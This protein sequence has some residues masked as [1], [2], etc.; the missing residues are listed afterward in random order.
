GGLQPGVRARAMRLLFTGSADSEVGEF[1]VAVIC[2]IY[3]VSNRSGVE[4]R[5]LVEWRFGSEH[6]DFANIFKRY[7]R[8][9]VFRT[10]GNVRAE[11]TGLRH[12]F[13]NLMR[14]CIDHR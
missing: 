14:C 11:G 3:V 8:F 13:D 4:Q 1:A 9:I 2:K 6:L 7:P 10:Y 5:N 12:A